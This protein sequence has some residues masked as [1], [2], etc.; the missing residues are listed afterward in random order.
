MAR[1]PLADI[2]RARGSFLDDAS[3]ERNRE[4]MVA[5]D[6]DLEARR[7]AVREGWGEKYVERVHRKGKLTAR[8]RIERLRDRGSQL[9]E[10]GTF[11]NY[12]ERFGADASAFI[13][14]AGLA[15]ARIDAERMFTFYLDLS[16]T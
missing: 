16:Q 3:Y 11:V 15:Y 14:G 8:E 5:R 12:G 10:V 4:A 6:E 2:G 9:F 1:V 13:D 7:A